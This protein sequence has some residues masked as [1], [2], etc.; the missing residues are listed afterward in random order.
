[1]QQ[2]VETQNI[3]SK[4]MRDKYKKK[5]NRRSLSFVISSTKSEDFLLSDSLSPENFQTNLERVFIS[6]NKIK[7]KL[8]LIKDNEL[9]EEV[10]WMTDALLGNQLNDII[11]KI[12]NENSNNKEDLKK[13][14]EL[15]AEYSSEFNFRRKIE[16]LQSVIMAKEVKLIENK[17]KEISINKPFDIRNEILDK[18]FNIFSFLEEVGRS[19]LLHI[20]SGNIF[21]Y[22]GLF[23]KVNQNTFTNFIEDIRDGYKYENPYHNVK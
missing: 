14:L 23:N 22:F 5:S 19:N 16:S 21:D 2:N 18:N 10:N 15:L 6:L 17:I 3:S 11:I 20:I 9:V 1:M 13:L 4:A 8:S 7:H 12:E